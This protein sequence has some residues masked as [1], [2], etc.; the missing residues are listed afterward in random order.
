[1]AAGAGAD[2][3]FLAAADGAGAAAAL[4]ARG[5]YAEATRGYLEARDGFERAV[6]AARLRP[7]ATSAP[8]DRARDSGAT[9][10]PAPADA[11]AATR[12]PA[13]GASPS[14]GFST[15][16][17]VVSPAPAAG[18]TGFE[19]GD[20]RRPVEFAGRL[21]FQ[22]VPTAVHGGDPFVVRLR[23]VNEGRRAVRV[24]SLEAFVLAAGRRTTVDVKVV[25]REV[26]PG[27]EAI[28]A[29]YSGEWHE[30]GPW[31]LE[32]LVVTD[33]DEKIASRLRSNP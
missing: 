21:L 15:E 3:S 20:A 19:P 28:V 13:E 6:R 10:V 8:A 4:A 31:M 22:V 33:R 24:R 12:T 7:A 17:T 32:A 29:E 2:A 5:E 1:V 11:R 25:Q 18:P 9:A 26:A 30:T 14:H 27:R 23:L 16:G